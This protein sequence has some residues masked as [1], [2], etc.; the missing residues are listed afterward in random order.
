MS[1][2]KEDIDCKNLN[3]TRCLAKTEGNRFIEFELLLL[4]L[5]NGNSD[6]RRILGTATPLV[7]EHWLGSDVLQSNRVKHI[8]FLDLETADSTPSITTPFPPA[9]NIQKNNGRKVAHLTV[10][11]GGM[12]DRG[13]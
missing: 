9:K 5:Q 3:E 11:D 6:T 10:F 8:R 1:H 2:H 7:K 13:A 12:N 4:P